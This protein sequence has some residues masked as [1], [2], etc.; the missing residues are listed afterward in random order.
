M[1]RLVNE[2]L[3]MT[4]LEALADRSPHHLSGG[5]LQRVALA[6][7]VVGNCP[8][9][10]LDDPTAF[11]D[12]AGE[13]A[14]LAMLRRLS[15]AGHTVFMAS[16]RLEG[17]AEHADR[18]IALHEGRLVLDGTPREVLTSARMKSI[19]LDWPRCAK[20]SALAR[21]HGFWPD[22]S[23]PDGPRERPLA[24]TLTET[25]SG[26]REGASRNAMPSR[27]RDS[28][29]HVHE[30]R[31]KNCP[32]I[33]LENVCFD[34]GSGPQALNGITLRLGGADQNGRGEAIALLGR[35]GSGKS[36]L[37]RHFNGLL[38][39]TQGV[40]RVNGVP[41]AERRVAQLARNVAL[42]FQNPDDQICKGT[43][44]DEVAF[45]PVSLGFPQGRVQELT[46]AALVAMGL[47]GARRSNP[48]DLGSS[49]RKRLAIASV[50]AMDSDMVVLD[51][52]TAGL[53]PGETALL[54]AA[55]RQLAATGKSVV[56]ISHDMD[57]VVENLHRAICLE[58][59]K[60]SYDGPVASLFDDASILERCGLVPPQVVQLAAACNVPLETM[61]PEGLIGSLV[62]T[63]AG[64]PPS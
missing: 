55:I 62:Q 16:Q 46:Q 31:E 52:P 24:I 38:K 54:Q 45:G 21:K 33:L 34:Y 49:A 14:V 37:V 61:T 3:R 25:I 15:D 8:V 35:N 1:P 63:R 7:A 23:S 17:V 36:T 58:A 2:A 18:V 42:L 20:V 13:K 4:G 50:L 47:D 56:V 10:V 53:D 5:Q 26:L 6:A 40:V 59:G 19:G 27:P 57:F 64:S 39:P 29:V 32:V 51:E 43:V 11:L 12:P 9:L 28:R 30:N 22:A 60:V 48:Y 41:T 44:L